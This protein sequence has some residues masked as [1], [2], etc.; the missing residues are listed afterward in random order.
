[1]I[2][3]V[4]R[5]FEIQVR[6]PIIGKVFRHLA[7]SAGSSSA[8]I[9]GHSNIEGIPTDDVM[10]VGGGVRARFAGGIK[11]LNRQG[12]AWK[13]KTGLDK[14]SKRDDSWKHLHLGG[15]PIRN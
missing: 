3:A 13:A 4:S 6:S 15:R 1:M 11:A 12:R 10:D 7:R 2:G 9:A 8:N 14:R 5:V